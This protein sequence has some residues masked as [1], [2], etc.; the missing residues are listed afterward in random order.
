[1]KFFHKLFFVFLLLVFV[2]GFVLCLDPSINRESMNVMLGGNNMLNGAAQ[3]PQPPQNP[4]PDLLI[5]SGTK[6]EL[7][8]T[9]TPKSDTNPLVFENLPEYLDYLEAQRKQ[10]IRCPVL[11]LQEETNTQGQTVFRARPGPNQMLSG[12]PVQPSKPIEILDA[13]RDN[14]PYNENH[15]AGFDA[16]GQHIGEFTEL[17]KIHQSTE[18]VKISDNPMDTNWGGP[19]FSRNA[20]HSGKYADREVS[21]PNM[22]PQVLG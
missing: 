1:M 4:C 12:L 22:V 9:S 3:P 16:H 14:A 10:N 20:V 19:V 8:N 18:Q 21:R 11:F 17:D 2:M 6:L 13:S 5:R 15:Y 7:L